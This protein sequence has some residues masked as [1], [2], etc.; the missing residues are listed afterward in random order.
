MVVDFF[1]F[2]AISCVKECYD[3]KRLN[4]ALHY[5]KSCVFAAFYNAFLHLW[6]SGP[7][8]EI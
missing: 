8:S 4:G 7:F 1:F 2:L 6:S 3:D 5:G